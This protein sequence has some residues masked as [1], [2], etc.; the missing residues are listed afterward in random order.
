MLDL[1]PRVHLDEE[2]LAVL[3]E[4]FERAGALVAELLASPPVGD[5]AERRALVRVERGRRRL[6]EQLLVLALQRAVALAEMD[7]AALAVAQD[8]HLDMAR[9]VEI[10]LE[11]DRAV[12]E[13]GLAPRPG[14]CGTAPRAPPRRA[15]RACRARRRRPPP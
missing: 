1:K 7:D 9:P 14:A 3:V 12:A 10:A 6:L 13:E 2:E 4:E 8:L 11:I 15:R 5:A